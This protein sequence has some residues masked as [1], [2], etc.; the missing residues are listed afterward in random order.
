[1]GVADEDEEKKKKREAM[2]AVAINEVGIRRWLSTPPSG[3]PISVGLSKV[4]EAAIFEHVIDIVDAALFVVDE[5]GAVLVANAR[6]RGM[7]EKDLDG[8][9]RALLMVGLSEGDEASAGDDGSS[10]IGEGVVGVRVWRKSVTDGQGQRL[11]VVL[12][13]SLETATQRV[14][15]MAAKAWKLTP[16]QKDVFRLVLEGCSNKEIGD[17]LSM[18]IRTVEVHI[19]AALEKAGVDSRSRLIAK[20]WTLRE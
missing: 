8:S 17:A 19:G 9:T 10:A 2:K 6:G 15:D 7:L 11:A 14:L 5:Y 3:A 13:D 12:V 16:R 18:A 4:A 20:A 1:M